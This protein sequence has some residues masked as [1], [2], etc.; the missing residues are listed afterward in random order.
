MMNEPVQEAL[1]STTDQTQ[2]RLAH[3]QTLRGIADPYLQEFPDSQP[4]EAVQKKYAA[5][6]GE[7]RSQEKVRLAGR[8]MTIR[9]HGK[10]AFADLVSLSGKMQVYFKQDTLGEA[11]W[12]R[13]E[14]LDLGDVVGVEGVVF[15]TRRGELSLHVEQ[16]APLAKCLYPLPEKWHGLKDVEVRYRQRYLDLIVNPEVRK[17]FL[18]RSRMVAEIR[19]FLDERHFHEVET[20]VMSLEAGG[21]AAR[22]FT[23]HH[24]ALELDLYLRIATELHLKRLIVGGLEKVYEIGRIFRNE[25]ISARHNPEFTSLEVY[26]AYSDYHGMMRLTE[27]L[28]VHLADTLLG[29]REI[30]Y[31]GKTV[32]LQPPFKRITYA[33]ALKEYGNIVLDEILNVEKAKEVARTLKISMPAKSNLGHYIDK[34]FETIVEPHLAQPTFILD[35]PIEISPLAKRK[36]SQPHL[37][38]R[39]ELFI[40][41]M[42]M[43]NAF[44]ELND[45]MDQRERFVKQSDLRES[46]DEEAH[47]MDED[48]LRALEFGMPPT[49]GLGIGIDRLCMLLTDSAS[50]R[51]VVLFPLLR[52]AVP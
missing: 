24:Q 9:L 19:R 34:I 6:Q 21:A 18:L 41:H 39:F 29:T 43:A 12:K 2:E 13:F 5:L 1:T 42:E 28:L 37:T 4:I 10:A 51:E 23:T 52:P 35:Y 8:L 46:G 33:E 30:P 15:R 22:P 11:G 17:I 20:P 47:M 38:E 44:S 45:P 16:V 14:L 50:I 3:L 48:F 27:A 26:E 32:S 31:Q 36:K 49:G 40:M 25:G 7:E